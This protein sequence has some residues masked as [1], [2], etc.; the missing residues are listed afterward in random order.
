MPFLIRKKKGR[1]LYYYIVESARG[2]GEPRNVRQTY[3]GTP[4]N[5]LRKLQTPSATIRK[6]LEV[7]SLTIWMVK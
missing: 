6:A 1:N 7:D 4:D 3:L 2:N 5:L